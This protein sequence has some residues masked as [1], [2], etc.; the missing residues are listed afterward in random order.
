MGILWADTLLLGALAS[1]RE[2]GV[3]AASTRF[4]IVGT[5]AG[6]AITT[7]FAPQISLLLSQDERARVDSLFK[8]ATVWFVLLAW[9]VYLTVAIFSPALVEVFGSGFD[10]GAAVL[11]IVGVA[12]LYAS[13]AGPVDM[14]LLMGGR[15]T[16]SLANNVVALT[17]NILLNL[18]LIPSMGLKGA[19]LAWSASLVLMNLLPTLEVR[20]TMGHHP[21]GRTWLRAVLVAGGAIAVPQLLVRAVLGPDQLGLAVGIVLAGL[22]YIA[23]VYAQRSEFHL[24]AFLAGLRRSGGAPEPPEPQVVPSAGAARLGSERT[25][26]AS[27]TMDLPT[28]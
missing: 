2:A 25:T 27:T 14:L 17:V 15:S 1:T 3:Y 21:Y 5:F 16:L 13:S 18:A 12:F 4:L 6:M 26:A 23:A 7:A 8:T 10:D 28:P 11:S 24:D 9:P 19:A 20:H 22:V